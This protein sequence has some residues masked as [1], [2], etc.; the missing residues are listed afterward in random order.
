MLLIGLRILMKPLLGKKEEDLDA[1]D[2]VHEP[3]PGSNEPVGSWAHDME[4]TYSVPFEVPEFAEVPEQ[5]ELVSRNFLAG[6]AEKYR[7]QA[8]VFLES[9]LSGGKERFSPGIQYDLD[10]TIW[11]HTLLVVKLE[12]ALAGLHEPAGEDDLSLHDAVGQFEICKKAVR[13]SL[14][15]L[16]NLGEQLPGAKEHV[17]ALITLLRYIQDNIRALEDDL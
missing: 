12:R 4:E 9:V 14:A 1:G 15:A 10:T 3:R 5:K 17:P 8:R 2:F 16:K 6:V 13:E 7:S 11:Y